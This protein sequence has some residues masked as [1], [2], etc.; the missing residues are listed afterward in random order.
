MERNVS[1]LGHGRVRRVTAEFKGDEAVELDILEVL[2]RIEEV[3][4]TRQD[5]DSLMVRLGIKALKRAL[6]ELCSKSGVRYPSYPLLLAYL[7]DHPD[8]ED[9]EPSNVVSLQG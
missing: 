1:K 5:V 3:A 9:R 4:R 8:T 2:L 7:E 6:A